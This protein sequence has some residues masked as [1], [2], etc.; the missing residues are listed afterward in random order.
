MPHLDIRK[1][2]RDKL[3]RKD[4]PADAEAIT[5][6]RSSAADI[7]L[8][9]SAVS[10]HH[11]TFERTGSH[12]RI[13]DHQSRHGLKINGVRRTEAVLSDGDRIHI[14]P[15]EILFHIASSPSEQGATGVSPAEKRALLAQQASDESSLDDSHMGR[16]AEIDDLREE[17]ARIEA[18]L[19]EAQDDAAGRREELEREHERAAEAA[20]AEL[21]A[22][23]Q[24]IDALEGELRS[25][26][27]ELHVLRQ[28][29]DT[30]RTISP[31][32]A[33]DSA[34]AIPD[35]GSIDAGRREDHERALASLRDELAASQ[36]ARDDLAAERDRVQAAAEHAQQRVHVIE[37]AN[38]AGALEFSRAKAEL[39][40]ALAHREQL[41]GAF[42]TQLE[43][44]I[45][46]ADELRSRLLQTEESHSTLRAELSRSEELLLQERAQREELHAQSQALEHEFA[47]LESQLH[48][49]SADLDAASSQ[50]DLA[51]EELRAELSAEIATLSNERNDVLERLAE[52]T[53]ER[54]E[55]LS[56]RAELERRLSE[57][58]VTEAVDPAALRAM[59]ERITALEAALANTEQVAQERDQ[60]LAVARQNI[61]Q[62]RRAIA[63][64]QKD[65]D[66]WSSRARLA[67]AQVENLK[68]EVAETRQRIRAYESLLVDYVTQLQATGQVDAAVVEMS[69]EEIRRAQ[70][71][72][73]TIVELEYPRR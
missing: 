19:V 72:G 48:S 28:E 3:R 16:E 47:A 51:L 52:V 5:L 2:G 49:L 68:K 9:H 57:L 18:A 22:R 4:W 32:A 73:A 64:A 61:E 39:D 41:A 69:P 67:Q 38:A 46:S 65:R 56:Q 15:Y 1:K 26:R 21:A 40:Q 31:D 70:R 11:C 23:D 17:F 66:V 45:A 60:R 42:R 53:V 35:T 20:R 55:A 34:G 7:V 29:I 8:H 62:F 58:A 36:R 59:E 12:W 63:E 50:R 27:D 25:A 37:E 6:G 30:L 71:A 13:R 43:Q 14:G 44:A 24:R 10:R 33:A 54:D